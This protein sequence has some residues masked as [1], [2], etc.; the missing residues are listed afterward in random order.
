MSWIAPLSV[1]LGL[2]M[3][4]MA[5]GMP[6][7]FA[8]L[9]ANIVGV[10]LYMG[11]EA[12]LHQL[13]LN[14]SRSISAFYLVPV[15]LFV[16]MGELFFHTG[17]SKRVF[18]AIDRLFGRVPGRLCYISVAGGSL[19]AS[20]SGSSIANTAMLGSML[21]PDME[22]R[23]YDKRF[24]MGPIMATGGLAVL[25]PPS[26]LAV[27][28]GSLAK[29]DIGALLIAGVLPGL[30]L[31]LMFVVY[32][33]IR[34]RLNPEIAP[35]Y[36]VDPATTR[37]KLRLVVTN[38]LPTGVIIFCVIGLI[39][40]GIATPTESAAFG[41]LGVLVV[42]AAFRLLTVQTL[43]RSLKASLKVSTMLLAILLASLTFSQVM[44][45]SGA[46]AGLIEMTGAL[47][48]GPLPM[49]LI[50]F[51]VLLFLGM[52]IDQTSQMMLT[53]PIFIPLAQSL[54]F[55]PVWFG[56]IVLLAL[57]MSTMT[58]PFGLLLFVMVGAAPKGTTISDVARAAFP[59]LVIDL[60]LLAL[61][62]AFPQIAL[63]L[64]SLMI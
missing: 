18:H 28:L 46:T 21:V 27:L 58:P 17:V 20:L 24:A 3:A 42:A 4:M 56:L 9:T 33:Y 49:L 60:I 36:P 32:I 1:M 52:F 15:P 2:V 44:A 34:V 12:G 38:L 62:I 63:F 10:F 59:Y 48:L 8:F 54:G 16:L 61:L 43:Y 51:A 39:I 19:F 55:D 26:A 57:E 23:G 53:I 14:M 29:I 22:A 47:D 11:G 35:Q 50:M 31:A 30:L 40:L 37:E 64:P 5:I 6:V 45:F 13:I 41:V 25:I 7:A